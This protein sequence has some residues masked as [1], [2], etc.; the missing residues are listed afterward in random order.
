MLCLRGEH[1]QCGLRDPFRALIAAFKL[2]ERQLTVLKKQVSLAEFLL[3][4]IPGLTSP[5]SLKNSFADPAGNVE[6]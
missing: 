1:L 4:F 3:G 5:Y 2:R 6:C